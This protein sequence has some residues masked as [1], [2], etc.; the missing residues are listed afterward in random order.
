MRLPWLVRP[1]PQDQQPRLVQRKA[2]TTASAACRRRVFGLR[3][4]EE[5]NSNFRRTRPMRAVP[6]LEPTR[7][8]SAVAQKG[9]AMKPFPLT[10]P[11]LHRA[12]S[13][14]LAFGAPATHARS[15]DRA[16][17][18]RRSARADC[19]CS[20]I[21]WPLCRSMTSAAT[22][23]TCARAPRR[24]KRR[25]RETVPL[26]AARATRSN[27][28]AAE[29][30]RCDSGW[31]R[32]APPARPGGRRQGVAAGRATDRSGRSNGGQASGTSQGKWLRDARPAGGATRINTDRDPRAF[33]RFGSL[34]DRPAARRE[35]RVHRPSR[36]N[37]DVASPRRT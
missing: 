32:R 34:E 7:D 13:A 3:L 31:T 17:A 30:S 24:L 4:S 37:A 23:R 35:S 22:A 28:A 29:S 5:A 11:V 2:S 25:H 33:E 36:P 16:S 10:Q 18:R 9:V 6:R 27:C 21:A 8:G 20:G 14:A 15:S 12:P 26:A 1:D 19:M